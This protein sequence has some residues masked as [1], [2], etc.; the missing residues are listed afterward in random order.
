VINLS[1]FIKFHAQSTPDR[2]AII[3]QGEEV[4]YAALFDRVERLAGFMQERGIGVGS[5][6]A[7]LMKN[8]CA[9][10]EIA[11]AASHL[12]AVLLPINY[13]LSADEVDYI[14]DNSGTELLF[15]DLE[16]EGNSPLSSAV[17]VTQKM[18]YDTSELSHNCLPAA[19]HPVQP[20]DLFRLMY[21]SGTTD[22]PKG[23]M[24][25]YEN[26]HWKCTDHTIVLGLSKDSRLLATGPLYHVGAFDLPGLTVLWLG[27]LMVIQR[28]FEAQKSLSLI[29]KYQI[30]STW[31]APVMT[32]AILSCE[33]RGNYNLDSLRWVIGGG[34]KTPEQR[35][36]DFSGLFTNARYIDAYGLTESCSGDTFMQ[37]G[38]EIEKI[39]SVG[40]PTPH[41]D[42][43][44]RG[45]NGAGMP[46]GKA[47]EIC[48]RGPKIFKQYWRD[49]DKT[50]ASFYGNWFRTGDVGYLD[51]E[52]FLYI[53][54]RKKDL[55]ISGGEN[56]ASSE[57][58]RVIRLFPDV[59]DVA[60]VAKPDKKWGEVPVAIIVSE[61]GGQLNEE[62]LILHCREKL[63]AFK[64]PKEVHQR[65]L[66]PRNPSGKVM[67]QELRN[68]FIG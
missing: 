32:S 3:Y 13:R 27:G 59:E 46:I 5:V 40:T 2:T 61:S 19:M 68:E 44:I 12:G 33:Q 48:L 17:V 35:I 42:V 54:D 30:N 21:T 50:A 16:F 34:E 66:L 7:V 67:K 57:V 11:F 9:F 29:E 49:P 65:P 22:R 31:L 60:V 41:V 58:E 1:S 43:E 4:S 52:G 47:G 51:D 45:D 38:R 56:I 20:K 24:H 53:S 15:V 63:A 8:S 10:L 23:V 14:C 64:V 37:P 62:E 28:E 39:G 36:I 18:Q 6:V 26:F 55:I 25:S